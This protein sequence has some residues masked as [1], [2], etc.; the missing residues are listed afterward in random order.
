IEETLE[1]EFARW[2]PYIRVSNGKRRNYIDDLQILQKV[3][4]EDCGL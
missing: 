3:T 2:R 4:T 1:R